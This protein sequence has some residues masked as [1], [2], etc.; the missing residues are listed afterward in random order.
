MWLDRYGYEGTLEKDSSV[1]IHS[2]CL[3]PHRVC[4]ER[5]PP[6][7][8]ISPHSATFVLSAIWHG[9]YPGYYLC[10]VT[11]R[12]VNEAARKV[13]ENG[14]LLWIGYWLID[15]MCSLLFPIGCQMRKLLHHHFQTSPAKKCLYDL[16]TMVATALSMHLAG[17]CFQL[18]MLDRCILFWRYVQ[19]GRYIRML[20]S[21]FLLFSYFYF[22][23]MV[24]VVMVSFLPIPGE[25]R[26]KGKTLE[27]THW[28]SLLMP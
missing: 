12:F 17:S 16:V 1:V 14:T 25:H 3:F 26:S 24:V 6:K 7:M 21:L 13:G 8:W 28:M 4:Y 20:T 5:V 2:M 22:V 11:F 9:F 10:F 27:K 18:L 15:H 19:C 23:P